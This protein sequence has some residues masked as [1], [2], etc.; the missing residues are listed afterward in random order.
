MQGIAVAFCI[1]AALF[2]LMAMMIDARWFGSD[3]YRIACIPTSFLVLGCG[4]AAIASVRLVEPGKT[5]FLATVEAAAFVVAFG[6]MGCSGWM[7]TALAS[8]AG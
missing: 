1:V 4:I 2:G 8:G 3:D 7:L 5:A 6:L